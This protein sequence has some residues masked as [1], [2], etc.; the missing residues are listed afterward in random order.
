MKEALVLHGYRVT[1]TA[2][3]A[4]AWEIFR[5]DPRGFA[6]LVT[7]QHMSRLSGTELAGMVTKLSP[8]LPVILCSGSYH[9]IDPEKVGSKGV[10]RIMRKPF[11]ISQLVAALGQVLGGRSQAGRTAAR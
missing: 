6:A 9:T 1:A 10:V 4:K 3:S 8:E 11:G 2:S 7:D 5:G